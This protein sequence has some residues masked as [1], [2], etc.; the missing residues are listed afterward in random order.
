MQAISLTKT[1]QPSTAKDPARRALLKAASL[2]AGSALLAGAPW[3]SAF[4][5]QT[6]A[7]VIKNG[8]LLAPADL[9]TN[10]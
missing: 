10:H 8:W 2:G 1:G 3:T 5:A 6:A 4:A 9:D 7:P